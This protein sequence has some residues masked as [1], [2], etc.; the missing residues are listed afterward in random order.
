MPGSSPPPAKSI[1]WITPSRPWPGGSPRE[2]VERPLK[3]IHLEDDPND[4]EIVGATLEQ[5]GV[6]CE[7]TTVSTKDDFVRA[8]ERE[9]VDLILSDYGLPGFDG[10]SALSI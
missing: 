4:M 2:I 8:L 5:Q 10:L 7:V 9:P 6:R 3:I 1:L